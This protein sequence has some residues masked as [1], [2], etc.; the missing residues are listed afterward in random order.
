MQSCI[1]YQNLNKFN[2]SIDEHEAT[3]TYFYFQT[4][5]FQFG[6]TQINIDLSLDKDIPTT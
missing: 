4:Q 2:V 3:A 5:I 1:K 6:S